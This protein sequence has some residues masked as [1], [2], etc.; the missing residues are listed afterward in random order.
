MEGKVS[1][2]GDQIKCSICKVNKLMGGMVFFTCCKIKISKLV[3]I[4][5]QSKIN[6]MDCNRKKADTVMFY[7]DIDCKI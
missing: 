6:C 4:K 2:I 1:K 3:C 5:C 7:I